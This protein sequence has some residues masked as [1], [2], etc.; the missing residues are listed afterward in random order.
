MIDRLIELAPTTRQMLVFSL[1]QLLMWVVLL[2]PSVLLW[3]DSVPYLVF[4]SVWALVL[5]NLLAVING[6]TEMYRQ[7]GSE[8]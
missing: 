3:R 1:T 6:L 4:I 2:P 7:R 8:T 5:S